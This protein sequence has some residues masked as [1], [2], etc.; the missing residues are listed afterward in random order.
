MLHGVPPPAPKETAE[1]MT[2]IFVKKEKML[3]EK[4]VAILEKIIKNRKDIEHGLK[5]ETTG[6]EIDEMLDDSD[7][8]L[9]R[10]NRLF[11]QIEKIKEEKDM[12]NIY[13][14]IV[15]II[16]DVLR[17]EG[18]EKVADEEVVKL[19]E[20]ELIAEGKIP[21]KF[22]RILNEIIKAKKDYDERKLS[23]QEVEKVKRDSS[24][25]IKFLVEYMQR[26]RGRELERAKIRVKHGNRYGEVLLLG[27]QAFIIHDID[28]EEKEISKASINKDGSLGTIA[29]SSLEEMEKVL[30]KIEIPPKVFIKEKIFENLKS[31]FGK[32]VEVLINY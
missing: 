18:I 2:E 20:D 28:K 31:V 10:I 30:A 8:Y 6:K 14:T 13:D 23:K 19:F 16:R 12:L 29:S 5:K 4:Y 9:K 11:T 26:K 17:M 1:L 21:A 24:A 25:F 32:D 7:K 22:L 15:T 3:E 27:E